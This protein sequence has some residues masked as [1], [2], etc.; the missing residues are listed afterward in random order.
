MWFCIGVYRNESIFHLPYLKASGETMMIHPLIPL[1]VVIILMLLVII[2][3]LALILY[4]L[5][6]RK[7]W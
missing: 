3:L 1:L 7:D 5:P 4:H 6:E 2:G